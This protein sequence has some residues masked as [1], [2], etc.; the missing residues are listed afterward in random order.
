M[1]S[2]YRNILFLVALSFLFGC[3]EK[4]EPPKAVSG[5]K[6][7]IEGAREQVIAK[8][9]NGNPKLAVYVQ[10]TNGTKIAEVEFHP[11]GQPKIDKRFVNDTLNGE[12]WCYY[13]DGKPWSLNTFRNGLNNGPYKT[14]HDNGQLYIDGHY[15]DGKEDGDW[16]TYYPTGQ[17]NTRGS[18]RNGEKTGV[19][20]SYNL[21]GTNKREQNF[22]TP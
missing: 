1:N 11:N 14:W 22:E 8:H 12:S 3:T 19:W 10:E 15:V 4:P 5:L 7:T 17:L 2:F 9:E 16:F 6:F 21:E 20:T 18:Y 13:E